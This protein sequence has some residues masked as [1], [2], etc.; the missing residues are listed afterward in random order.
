[1]SGTRAQLPLHASDVSVR[2]ERGTAADLTSGV[3][4]RYPGR[5]AA[6]PCPRPQLALHAQRRRPRPAEPPPPPR[7]C[8]CIAAPRRHASPRRC[9]AG[10]A[11]RG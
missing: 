10:G 2:R 6:H 9:P 11:S 4:F 7:R 1:M 8:A 3:Q 5:L